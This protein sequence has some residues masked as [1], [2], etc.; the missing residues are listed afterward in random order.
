MPT[1][2][3]GYDL[4]ETI[5][6][7]ANFLFPTSMPI[8]EGFFHK[9]SDPFMGT[10]RFEGVPIREFTDPR[11]GKKHKTGTTDTM[12][13]RK[14]DVTIKSVPGSG[15]T[16]IELVH[17]SLRSCCPIEVQVGGHAQ[18]WD[19]HLSLSRSKPSLGTMTITHE[20]EH[21]GHFASEIRPVPVFRFERRSDG[22]ERLLDLGALPLP[23]EKQELVVRLNTL[24][25]S[26]VA[27]TNSPL[28]RENAVVLPELTGSFHIPVPIYHNAAKHGIR[29]PVLF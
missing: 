3:A 13:F 15:T 19:V 2:T 12:V 11:T 6:G 20:S 28:E 27:W 1:I 16:E 21:G 26:E 25:A 29:R 17:L 4:F 8:P 24:Q 5:P 10:I 22:V 7:E 14:Q 23:A 9:G 18:R